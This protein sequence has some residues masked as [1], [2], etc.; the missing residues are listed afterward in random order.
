[1]TITRTLISCALIFLIGYAFTP[2]QLAGKEQINYVANVSEDASSRMLNTTL[3]NQPVADTLEATVILNFRECDQKVKLL[4]SEADGR[5]HFSLL[6]SQ[7]CQANFRFEFSVRQADF[8]F[9]SSLLVISDPATARSNFLQLDAETQDKMRARYLNSDRVFTAFQGGLYV[10]YY[11]GCMEEA[12][13]TAP[14][15][16]W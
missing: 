12:L 3:Q 9:F 15:Q 5:Y 2:E 7:P 16:V 4:R 6:D 8:D 1:M 10:K 11:S 14:L 13:R